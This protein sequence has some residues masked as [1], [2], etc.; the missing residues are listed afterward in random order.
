M[1][2]YKLNRIFKPRHVAVVVRFVLAHSQSKPVA[3]LQDLRGPKIRV[4]HIPDPGVRLEPGQN[5]ILTTQTVEGSEQRISIS[6]PRL[7]EEV[8]ADDRILPADSFWDCR[9][10]SVNRC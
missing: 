3:I 5:I 7:S 9:V 10:R 6:Y 4:G 8:K 2:Q 1:G